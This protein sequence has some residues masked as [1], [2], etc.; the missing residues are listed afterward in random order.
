MNKQFQEFIN[1]TKLKLKVYE[2]DYCAFDDF[3]D[4][5]DREMMVR[6]RKA[7]YPE[8]YGGKE[9]DLYSIDKWLS[10]EAELTADEMFENLDYVRMVDDNV[11]TVYETFCFGKSCGQ[12]TI[13]KR[14][15]SF[16]VRLKDDYFRISPGTDK[17][18]HKKIEE[19]KSGK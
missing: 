8:N 19:L 14:D 6:L 2:M 5:E 11:K 4:D 10:Q 1:E 9:N 12:I 18:I 16:A 7:L 15:F 17:A 13:F 3:Y